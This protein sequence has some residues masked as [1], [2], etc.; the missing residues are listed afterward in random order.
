MASASHV[1]I[2]WRAA[3]LRDFEAIAERIRQDSPRASAAFGEEVLRRAGQLAE[4]PLLGPAPRRP[5]VRELLLAT[6]PYVIVYQ[7]RDEAVRIV[8]I[9]HGRRR[10]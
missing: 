1:K 3:A 6:A 10:R 8:R 4:F 7:V 5:D 2:V 9:L